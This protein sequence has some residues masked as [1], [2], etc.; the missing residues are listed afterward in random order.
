M[1]TLLFNHYFVHKCKIKKILS[2]KGQQKPL[3]TQW[4]WI[5]VK[6]IY[7]NENE[8]R[9]SV[10]TVATLIFCLAEVMLKPQLTSVVKSSHIITIYSPRPMQC[11][12]FALLSQFMPLIIS[13]VLKLTLSAVCWEQYNISTTQ[14]ERLSTTSPMSPYFH[15]DHLSLRNR[16]QEKMSV[17]VWLPAPSSVLFRCGLIYHN[18]II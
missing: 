16:K 7:I 2:L 18:R 13:S 3:Q 5:C 17:V 4:L 11:V 6:R 14:G 1:N 9:V 12:L 8:S 10:V 15:A